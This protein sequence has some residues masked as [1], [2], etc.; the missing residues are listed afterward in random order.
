MQ[1]ATHSII[2]SMISRRDTWH[3]SYGVMPGYGWWGQDGFQDVFTATATMALEWGALPFAKGVI[4]NQFSLYVRHDGLVN[5]RAIE[6]PSCSRFLTLLALYL[7]YS[8][9]VDLLVK[10][11]DKAKALASWLMHRRTLSLA[12]PPD[13]PRYGIPLGNDEADS[14]SHTG[15]FS[16]SP[17]GAN[18]DAAN[19]WLG[20]A[21]RM[22]HLSAAAEMARALTEMGAAWQRVGTAAQRADISTHGTTLL[23][24]AP[25]LQHD[26]H[27]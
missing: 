1:Q 18:P 5:Y 24:V 13:D 27:A 17:H 26:L 15:G 11:F 22:H 4:D 20:M 8:S 9:D 2:R 21:P 16:G 10:L 19:P 6:V 25:Q 3:P 7:S 23:G 12:L 14:Y